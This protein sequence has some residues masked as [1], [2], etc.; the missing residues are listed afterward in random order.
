LNIDR[1][2]YSALALAL[3]TERKSEI[4]DIKRIRTL[5][6]NKRS[7]EDEFDTNAFSD[8]NVFYKWYIAQYISQDGKCYYCGTDERI[9]AELLERLYSDRKRVKRGLHLEI[10]RK[11]KNPNIYTP[12]NCVLACYFCNNDK[13]DIFTEIQYRAYLKDRKGFFISEHNKL[14]APR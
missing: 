14:N 9:I 12:S 4:K 1:K 7:K 10:E 13:S 6:Y 5:Y 3:D 8:F 11:E 2:E